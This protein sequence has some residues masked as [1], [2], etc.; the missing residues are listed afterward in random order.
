MTHDPS[1][2]DTIT[3]GLAN[4]E[5]MTAALALRDNRL[6]IAEPILKRHLKADPFDAAAIRM[7]A[8]LAARIGR[9]QD[10]EGLLRRALEIAPGFGAARANLAT[11]LYRQNRVRAAPFRSWRQ[12]RQNKSCQG[13]R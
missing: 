5:L 7:L 2:R 11:V 6:E 10:S 3:A 9:L 13:F 4:P 1:A 12:A 8:E